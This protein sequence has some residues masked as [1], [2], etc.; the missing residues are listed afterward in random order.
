MLTDLATIKNRLALDPFDTTY[1]L[2]LLRAI[3]AVSARLNCETNRSLA[4][5][6][7]A[8][9][10]FSAR[11]TDILV[12]CYPIESVSK[13]ELKCSETEGWVEQPDVDFLVTRNCVIVLPLPLSAATS[14]RA[15]A[16]VTYTGG[17]LVPGSPD[18]PGATRLPAELEQA[19]V[20]QTAYWFQTREKIGLKRQWPQG[21]SYEEFADP[22]L[23]PS[24]RAVLAR[25]TRLVL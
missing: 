6:E 7:N 23:L 22:D 19:A 17:Y 11:D 21:G 9:Y 3:V 5:T 2:L 12:P 14:T 13:F 10:E 15:I 18:L 20:E 25:Y 8:S 4:R 16:R 1:D 24:V